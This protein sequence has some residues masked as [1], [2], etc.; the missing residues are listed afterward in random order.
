MLRISEISSGLWSLKPTFG[1]KIDRS[2]LSVSEYLASKNIQWYFG[3]YCNADIRLYKG[4]VGSISCKSVA[5]ELV[6][7]MSLKPAITLIGEP[8]ELASS[9]YLF[10]STKST[11][12]VAPG[13]TFRRLYYASEWTDPELENWG[14]RNNRLCWIA[15]PTSERISLA[16]KMINAGVP[17]DIYSREKWPFVN[18]KGYAEDESTIS[19]NYKYRIVFENSCQYGYH[20]EKLFNSIRCGCV[21]FYKGDHSLYASLASETFIPLTIEHIINRDHLCG[22]ILQGIDTFMFSDAWEIYS[23]KSFYDRIIDLAV[24]ALN[25]DR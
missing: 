19:S 9:A 2:G 22:N 24:L 14:K 12:A 6:K 5:T 23:F 1:M 11:L 18:W 17:V 15:R 20:S 3:E 13:D 10:S 7:R 8:R 4:G 16:T 25:T 21:T